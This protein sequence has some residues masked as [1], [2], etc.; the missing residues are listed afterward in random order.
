MIAWNSEH[1]LSLTQA[2]RE[3]GKARGD[4]GPHIST[5]HRWVNDGRN[6]VRLET[7]RMG[8]QRYTSREALQ[9][10]FDAQERAERAP[11]AAVAL[12]RDFEAAEREL[13]RDGL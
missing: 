11:E 6:G 4:K 5:L 9:R 8:R 10:F 1:L 7:L 3:L 13:E 12:G 2:A